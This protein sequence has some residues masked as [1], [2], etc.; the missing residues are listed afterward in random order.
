M[1]KKGAEENFRAFLFVDA[2]IQPIAL[3]DLDPCG[4]VVAVSTCE[5]AGAVDCAFLG[6]G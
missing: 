1:P 2:I 5:P 6:G 3:H 4:D